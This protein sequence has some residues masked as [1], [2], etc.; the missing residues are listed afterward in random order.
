[1]IGDC[2]AEKVMCFCVSLGLRSASCDIKDYIEA[3][4]MIWLTLQSLQLVV[5]VSVIGE[6]WV[7]ANNLAHESHVLCRLGTR[8][9][10]RWW[11][12]P[13]SEVTRCSANEPMQK[14]CALEDRWWTH[15]SG[16]CRGGVV[17][18][19]CG[20]WRFSFRCLMSRCSVIGLTVA[21]FQINFWCSTV[22]DMVDCC[23]EEDVQC[24]SG[25]HVLPT[26]LCSDRWRFVHISFCWL[27]ILCDLKIEQR[28][29]VQ[30]MVVAE[31]LRLCGRSWSSVV[32]WVLE[33]ALF[34]ICTK[35]TLSDSVL[36]GLVDGVVH[37]DLWWRLPVSD[38]TCCLCALSSSRSFVGELCCGR[39]FFFGFDDVSL[40]CDC[41]ESGNCSFQFRDQKAIGTVGVPRVRLCS[42]IFLLGEWVCI[43]TV[44][45]DR[46]IM[47]I[48]V[49]WW[50]FG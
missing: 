37:T 16:G 27:W 14:P 24:R 48:L 35:Q 5:L 45:A 50:F 12:C 30:I 8:G 47:V 31:G 39:A 11:A 26:N 6:F 33:N 19:C 10:F 38:V 25:H 20:I 42:S 21:M 46:W 22:T 7:C 9:R 29:L 34:S 4:C 2:Q 41:V 23:R 36:G 28:D 44:C 15:L 32:V 13:V 49:W 40:L 1:M 17:G 3:C 18:W 43:L